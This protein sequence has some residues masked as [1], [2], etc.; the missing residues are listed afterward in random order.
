MPSRRR[1]FAKALVDNP[2]L[3]E[4][5]ETPST[6]IPAS[7]TSAIDSAAG[8]EDPLIVVST[9]EDLPSSGSLG[10]KGF[11]QSTNR[12]YNWSGS[13]WYNIAVT[14][15]TPT[16]DS[17]GQPNS[18]YDLD[19]SGGDPLI[20]NLA[21]T[22]PDGLPI[23]YS[24]TV[25][26]SAQYV[27]NIVQDSSQITITSKSRDSLTSTYS[28]SYGP[29]SFTSTFKASDGI[30][31]AAANS[32]FTLRFT[33]PTTTIVTD[34]TT[35]WDLSTTDIVLS[36]AQVKN[37]YW[38]ANMILAPITVKMWG[39]GG[40]GHNY[41]YGGN[42]GGGGGFSSGTIT[43]DAEI[44][45]TFGSATG[46]AMSLVVGGRGREGSIVPSGGISGVLSPTGGNGGGSNSYGNSGGGGK[47]HNDNRSK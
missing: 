45:A 23:S 12:L 27:A 38:D 33:P 30:N 36:V 35:T 2:V 46:R 15:E 40:G 43:W 39:A 6:S 13:G 29:F 1:L 21:A 42:K 31:Y 8:E 37:I 4:I 28:D 10:L 14:N 22:D 5:I 25:S 34:G 47:A 18:S 17:G 24:Y 44:G 19:S 32:E 11:V 16:W 41:P 3:S 26:D 7:M 9:P 20:I